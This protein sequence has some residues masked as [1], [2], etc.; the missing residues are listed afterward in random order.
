MP[1]ACELPRMRRAVVPRVRSGFAVVDE[2]VADRLPRCA[3][4]IRTLNQL[5][6]P[7]RRLRGIDPVRLGRRAFHMIDLPTREMRTLDLPLRAFAVGRK[8]ERALARAHEQPD[9][10]HKSGDGWRGS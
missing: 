3:A 10:T 7:T 9:G 2:L 6:E 8:D 4:I 1:D 5:T